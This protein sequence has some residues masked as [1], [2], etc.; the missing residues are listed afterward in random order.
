MLQI[1]KRANRNLLKETASYLY[2]DVLT[3][4]KNNDKNI[5]ET[6]F[7]NQW[8]TRKHHHGHLHKGE[9]S[10]K[11]PPFGARGREKLYDLRGTVSKFS[12]SGLSGIWQTKCLSVDITIHKVHGSSKIDQLFCARGVVGRHQWPCTWQNSMAN[13]SSVYSI[14]GYSHLVT[15]K[16]WTWR[17]T[18]VLYQ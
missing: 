2:V 7:L 15:P 16:T 6:C 18:S 3:P 13:V 17:R 14:V 1:E 9:W 4:T 11:L 10:G 12:Y 8:R 5:F